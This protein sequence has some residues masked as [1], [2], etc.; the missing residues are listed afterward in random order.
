MKRWWVQASVLAVAFVVAF[1]VHE[2]WAG[3]LVANNVATTLLSSGLG[4]HPVA[5]LSAVLFVAFRL[6]ALPLAC[7]LGARVAVSGFYAMQAKAVRGVQN[8]RAI[9]A[10]DST[11]AQRP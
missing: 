11:T 9:R 6:I 7:G 1:V 8:A 5:S 2:Q 3:T 4:R 10:R